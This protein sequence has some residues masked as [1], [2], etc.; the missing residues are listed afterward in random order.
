MALPTEGCY[1]GTEV[2]EDTDCGE[3]GF[4]C[5]DGTCVHGMQLCDYRYDC[6]AT[7][8]DELGW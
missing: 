4:H 2:E 1:N 7:G 8:R 6:L 5:G 3:H